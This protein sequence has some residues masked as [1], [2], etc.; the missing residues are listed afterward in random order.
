MTFHSGTERD[1][2]N[3]FCQVADVIGRVTSICK[4]RTRRR[5]FP[6]FVAVNVVVP[7]YLYLVGFP[8]PVPGLQNHGTRHLGRV[9]GDRH[10]KP[11]AID[12]VSSEI[13][14][15]KHPAFEQI[16]GLFNYS[17]LK[18]GEERH[19]L[20]NLHQ[21]QFTLNSDLCQIGNVY[22]LTIVHSAL[23][24]INYRRRIRETFGSVRKAWNKTVVV[25]FTV[26]VSNN[27]TLQ[28]SVVR[29]ANEFKDMIQG[30]FIDVYRNL[31]IKH[32]MG[33]HWM[34]NHCPEAAFVLKMDDDMFMNPY[35]IVKYLTQLKEPTNQLLGAIA[36]R[37]APWRETKL[38]WYVSTAQYPFKTWP[39]FCR[40]LAYIVSKDV[41]LKLYHAS[42]VTR[43]IPMDDVFV[44]GVIRS[45]LGINATDYG[46][47][48]YSCTT[49][50]SVSRFLSAGVMFTFDSC[51][52]LT[53]K[54]V[55][56][57]KM[58]SNGTYHL[59]MSDKS[60]FIS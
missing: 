10:D 53:F 6:L 19:L 14:P 49:R 1:V 26:G 2:G 31:S 25:V 42:S 4:R 18:E 28:T 41:L 39:N 15:L 27:E 8:S 44:T 46:D 20:V 9:L 59:S 51:L 40:G 30:N 54:N 58:Y 5:V 52:K 17:L 12:T 16:P 24:H 7:L 35:V 22:L 36:H 23:D 37:Y 34:L 11:K 33:Y 32:I 45:N 55:T 57:M 56:A 48:R 38:K 21:Y 43:F 60:I 29:E 47:L 13:L 3:M 50:V